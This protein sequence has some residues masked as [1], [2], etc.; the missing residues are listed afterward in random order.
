[1]YRLA[2]LFL[3]AMVLLVSS[4]QAI[5]MFTNFHNGENIGYPPLEVPTK[6]YGH[7]G[8]HATAQCRPERIESIEPVPAMTPTGR[9]AVT[10]NRL[11]SA[12]SRAAEAMTCN[13]GNQRGD[14]QQI[15]NPQ[16]QQSPVDNQGAVRKRLP[17]FKRQPAMHRLS[18]TTNRETTTIRP[19]LPRP[20]RSLRNRRLDPFLG[21]G[22]DR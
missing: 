15:D 12:R 1:M 3:V 17:A 19:S 13:I 22:P 11:H 9:A 16:T 2:L 5:E 10:P 14:N 4:A 6:F 18:D 7:G 21:T 20:P 8:W